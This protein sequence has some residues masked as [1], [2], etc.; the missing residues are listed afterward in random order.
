[1]RY[2]IDD[3]LMDTIDT[4]EKA[5]WLGF[6]FA[7]AYNNEKLGRVVIELAEKD[8]SHL[9]KCANFFGNPRTPF[10][11]N[12]NHGKYV[13]YRLELNS[14]HLS[15]ALTHLGCGQRKSFTIKFPI[16]EKNLLPHFVRGYFDGDGSIYVRQD[17]L[18]AEMVSTNEMLLSM[19][20]IF[21]DIEVSSQ[22]RNP[23]RYL[24]NT[25]VLY[26][27]GSRQVTKLCHWMYGTAEVLLERKYKI[28][29]EYEK[30]HVYR[31]FS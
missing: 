31:N 27:G 9:T 3:T 14:R 24:N 2:H 11:Q 8:R 6:F 15:R 16:L 10:L 13:A 21:A 28:F 17:Q 23:P 5:Y 18:Y 25:F 20:K 4:Q 19:Q 7:D 29:S 26:T 1:M 12:K 30:I 22:I